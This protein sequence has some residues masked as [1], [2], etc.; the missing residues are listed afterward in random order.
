[1]RP[2]LWR[3]KKYKMGESEPGFLLELV[4]L[5]VHGLCHFRAQS[6]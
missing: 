1:M 4:E 3:L 2:R 5:V 6:H